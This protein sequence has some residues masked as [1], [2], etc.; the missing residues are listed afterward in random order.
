LPVLGG[1]AGFALRAWQKKR[2]AIGIQK[3][4]H[5]AYNNALRL[6]EIALALITLIGVDDINFV[7]LR[8][9]PGRAHRL[10]KTAIDT[11]IRNR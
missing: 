1:R 8:Y 3:T 11:I 9:S 7:T 10:A 6:I 4:I 2:L 5:R